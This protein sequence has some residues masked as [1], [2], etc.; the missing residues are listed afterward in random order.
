MDRTLSMRLNRMRRSLNAATS[1]L[2]TT[3]G[4]W[5]LVSTTITGLVA[6]SMAWL[7][8]SALPPLHVKT[9]QAS[10]TFLPYRLFSDLVQAGNNLV[11]GH[12]AR[13]AAP[14]P[15]HLDDS[16][17][18]E[19]A[20]DNG[21]PAPETRTLTLDSGDTLVGALEDAGVPKDDANAAVL[22]LAKIYDLRD[23]RAG[24]TFTTT[25]E[26][27]AQP[28]A[29]P[30][31]KPKPATA[32]VNV[33]GKPVTVAGSNATDDDS[34]GQDDVTPVTT[35]AGRLLSLA[36]SPSVEHDITVARQADNSFAA[37]D[38][39][40]ELTAHTHRAGATIDS[41][42]YL[43]ATQAGIP[44]D[45]TVAM[46]KLFSYKVDFQRDLRPGDTFEVYYSYYY[47]PD[48]L[49]ARE[50]NI[51]Y[52]MMHTGGHQYAV[53]RYQPD[54]NQPAEYFDA[55]G[56]SLK[57]ML[58]KTPVDGARISSG[59]GMRFHPVLGYTR[60]HKG[61]DFAVPVGTP[62]MASGS[63]VVKIAGRS[64]GYG[65]YMRVDM[66]NGYGFAYGHL[67]RFAP[68]IHPGSH[69][70]QGEIVAYSGN[71]GLSTGPHLHYETLVHN[72]QVNPLTLKIAQGRVLSGHDLRDF[73][74][75]KLHTDA[76]L[77]ATPLESKVADNAT[78]LRQAKA[79]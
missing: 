74:F 45:V 72:A 17:A 8:A 71:T 67:S 49:P 5:A 29:P 4:R 37:Q 53:Y 1:A 2:A 9:Q 16:L 31:A 38:T 21:A 22:A 20:G 48:G 28:P 36:F 70:H 3:D 75:G 56:E 15:A 46:I 39:V 54:P 11:A 34:S 41:S 44:T 66:G 62:V 30:A 26:A 42:L 51:D 12:P 32:V 35:P 64:S 19:D 27:V 79:R 57:G 47:T 18:D 50:G 59:F 55:H 68:G 40:K 58:M 14:P 7:A 78:E 65:N 6:G 23:A 77:A 69:V 52:A 24:Q 10:T 63:G 61:I 43:S 76:V 13:Q 60:M 73:L 33:N 25:F